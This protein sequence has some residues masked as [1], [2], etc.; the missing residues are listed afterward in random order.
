MVFLRLGAGRGVPQQSARLDGLE[1]HLLMH[2]S[3]RRGVAGGTRQGLAVVECVEDLGFREAR[4]DRYCGGE[5]R[6]ACVTRLRRPR[7]GL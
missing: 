7:P 4:F 2:V 5:P 6:G 3:Q 1:R